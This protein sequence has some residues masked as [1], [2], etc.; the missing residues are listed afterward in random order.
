MAR[1]A[2]S[3]PR[4]TTS[5]QYSFAQVPRA[6]IPR[7][8][9]NRSCG[10]KTTGDFGYIYPIFVD[11]ALP[12]DTFN[13]RMSSLVRLGTP[14]FPLMDNMFCDYFFF[15][16]PIRLVWNNFHKFCGAQDDPGDSTSYTIP[17]FTSA[18]CVEDSLSDYM[19]IPPG[20]GAKDW[21]S[22][23][24]R[25]YNL[26]WNEWFRSQDLCD[27][28]VVDKDDG[29]DTLG[30]YVLLRR[31]KRHDYFTSCLPFAQKGDA[32]TLPLGTSADVVGDGSSPT[33][34]VN[35]VSRTLQS[36]AT[37]T[38]ARWSGTAPGGTYTANWD[39]PHLVADLSTAT[40]A[41]INLIREAFQVQ[42]LLER[43]ARGGTRLT[44][45]IRSH[46][47]VISPD[48]RLQRPEYLGGGSARMNVTPVASTAASSYYVGELAGFG[49][50]LS[51]GIGFVKSFTEHCLVLGLMS[52]RADLTWQEGLH[53]MFS[54][55]D[56]FDFYWP[57][58]AFLGEQPVLSKE[59]YS[60]GTANDEDVFGYQERWAEYRYKPSTTTGRMRSQHSTS[61][62]PWHLG[63]DLG[64]RPTLNQTFLEEDPPVDRVVAT[65]TEPHWIGDFWFNFKCARPMPTYSVPGLIDHL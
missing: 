33:Y 65:P 47:G 21:N 18:T 41:T 36:E 32:V 6:D 40:A 49:V 57:A 17:Q 43:D 3:Q 52:A 28:V 64:A 54:R 23:W 9:F 55:Q 5:G 50:Q 16:I 42:K 20:G 35:A 59:I 58:L 56:R 19:G 39:D 44:E 12:G 53:R 37:G 15:A 51:D 26:V 11:E 45:I 22:L 62:D 34:L 29:P 38:G 7:S 30:D 48:Q 31:M 4:G 24:H 2:S 27:S 63:I 61:L 60:D 8:V 25:A 10:L 14:L 46:F 1:T 13:L